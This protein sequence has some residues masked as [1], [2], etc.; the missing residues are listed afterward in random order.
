MTSAKTLRS[1]VLCPFP[2]ISPLISPAAAA[3]HAP[4]TPATAICRLMRK[5]GAPL[6]LSNP[7]SDGLQTSSITHTGRS[8]Y[9]SSCHPTHTH[10]WASPDG[11]RVALSLKSNSAIREQSGTFRMATGTKDSSQLMVNRRARRSECHAQDQV[12]RPWG[13][14]EGEEVGPQRG[15]QEIVQVQRQQALVDILET[16]KLIFLPT[17]SSCKRPLNPLHKPVQSYV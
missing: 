16:A 7:L 13:P 5:C 2:L 3:P 4:C 9:R 17:L 11:Q 1:L 6:V 10:T 8:F 15:R 14:A 12:T